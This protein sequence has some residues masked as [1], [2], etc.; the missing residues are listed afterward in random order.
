MSKKDKIEIPSHDITN[1]S[2]TKHYERGKQNHRNNKWCL[3]FN[4]YL[5]K[6]C[7]MASFSPSCCSKVLVYQISSL[8]LNFLKKQTPKEPTSTI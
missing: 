3:C 5:N 8:D 4:V 2:L 6:T 7:F 1:V